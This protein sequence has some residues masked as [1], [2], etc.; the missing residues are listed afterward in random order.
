M[1]TVTPKEP[2]A[3]WNTQFG[4]W[5]T[6]ETLLCGHRTIFTGNWPTWGEVVN[7]VARV[8]EPQLRTVTTENP[9]HRTVHG[10]VKIGSL[11]SGYGGLEF[12]ISNIFPESQVVWHSDINKGACKVLAKRFPN[13]PNVGDITKVQWE[14]LERV[15][16]LA[17]GFPCQDVSLAGKRAGLTAE[18]RSGLWSH[19]AEA[20]KV[21]RPEIVVAENVRG[22]LTAPAGHNGAMWDC[23]CTEGALANGGVALKALGAV[24][25]DLTDSNYDIAWGG[26]KASDAGAAHGRFR[27]FITATTRKGGKLSSFLSSTNTATKPETPAGRLFGTPRVGGGG[28][29]SRHEIAQGDPKRRLE[30]QVALLPMLKPSNGTKNE[31]TSSDEPTLPGSGANFGLERFGNYKGSVQRWERVLGRAAPDATTQGRPGRVLLSPVFAEWLMGLPEGWVTGPEVGLSRPEQL[32]TLGNGVVP[33]QA[34][35]ALRSLLG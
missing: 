21:L 14:T 32:S 26:V 17:G 18:T 16:I 4:Y 12:G 35:L 13:T 9:E 30:V 24:L 34:E 28:A 15:D 23:W 22:L 29:P 20:V 33:Q 19:M 3:V 10:G 7:G 11:F 1:G 25:G 27:V 5:E 2:F 8:T 31:H 6:L